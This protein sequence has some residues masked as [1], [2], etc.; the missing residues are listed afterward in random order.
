MAVRKVSG[1]TLDKYLSGLR[2]AH[3][4]RGHFS[5]WMRP[6]VVELMVTRV[7]NRDQVKKRMEGKKGRLPVTPAMLRALR[8]GLK[9]A[10]MASAR[11]R[12]IWLVATWCWSGAFRIHEILARE[13]M[14]FDPTT[15]LLM[16]DVTISSVEVEGSLTKS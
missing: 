2:M 5:P 6:D 11:K 13:P 4:M 7:H 1:A 9:V 12:L 10:T 16:R 15:S 8:D 3:M 14:T